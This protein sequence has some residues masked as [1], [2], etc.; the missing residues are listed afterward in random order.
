MAPEPNRAKAIFLQAVDGVPPADRAAFVDRAC[1][2]DEAL[3]RRVEALLHA[4][5]T[6]FSLFDRPAVEQ[7][8]AAAGAATATI[9]T[10]GPR[11]A[12]DAPGPDPAAAPGGGDDVLRFLGPP[13]RPGSIGR[14]GH[15]E[16]LELLGGGAFGTVFKCFDEKLHRVVAV[17]ILAPALAACGTARQRFLR[18]ARAAAAVRD[19]HVIDIHAVEEQPIPYL[20]MEY[21]AGQTLQQ[22]LDKTGPLPARETL[23]IGYQVAAGLAAAHKLGLIHR[24]VKPSNILLENGVERVKLSDFGLARAVDDASLTQSG[25]VAGTPMYMA[26]E[27]AEGDRVDHRADLFSLGSVLYALCTG[28]PPFRARTT[29][30]VLRRVCEDTPRPVREVNPD[31]PDRLEAV[32]T[33]LLAKNPDDRFPS[34]KE[35][36]DV[37]AGLLSEH[38]SNG[39]PPPATPGAG[40]RAVGK[41]N[42]GP[43]AGSR[44][45]SVI[46]LVCVLGV[47]AAGGT[48][49]TALVWP[50]GHSPAPL[51]G[52]AAGDPG[53]AGE[54][55]AP[56]TTPLGG[57]GGKDIPAP[58]LALLGGGD[59]DA[60][61]EDLVAVLA[62]DRFLLSGEPV[63]G[64][65]AVSPDGRLL[66]AGTTGG[67]VALFETGTGRQVWRVEAHTGQVNRVAFRGDG[68]RLL[69]PS[70]DGTARLWDVEAGRLLQ[71]FRGH[72]ESVLAAVFG[73]AD[74]T[75]IT[76]GADATVRVW[77][78]GSG[79]ELKRLP[80]PG[81]VHGLAL[82][83]DGKTL[84]TGCD[85]GAVRTWDA[86]SW[87][88]GR[89]LE[90]HKGAVYAAAV[91]R[92]GK[93]L[94]TGGDETVVW[95]AAT[96]KPV[97][98]LSANGTWV[99][100]GPDGG[101]V[102]A[103]RC[104]YGDG[105][106]YV[107]TRWEAATGKR[108]PDLTPKTR[109][110]W[111]TFALTPDGAT[112]F[113]A[114]Q[115]P[116]PEPAVRAFDARTGD[117]R[118]SPRGHLG[119]AWTVAFSPNATLLASGGEDG[120]VRLWDLAGWRAGEPIPPVRLLG[121]HEKW[122]W[123]VRFSPDGKLLASGSLDRTIV[124]WDAATGEKVRTLR[125]HSGTFSRVA[126]APDGRTVAGGGEDGAVR[127][128]D[129]DTGRERG[130]PEGHAAAVR[131]VAYSPDGTRLA[132]AGADR[133]VQV[134]ATDSGQLLKRI[135]MP[136]ISD[137]VTFSADGRRLL[138]TADDSSLT[139]WDAGTW[140][141]ATVVAHR[142]FV[143]GLAACP[144]APLA[145]T[146]GYDGTV[147]L[148][149][150]R[151]AVPHGPALGGGLFDG[152]AL[153]VA[154]APD[155]RYLAA[156]TRNGPVV[157]RVPPPPAAYEPGPARAVPDPQELARGPAAADALDP[158]TIPADLRARAGDGDPG[159]VPAGLVAV[160]GGPAG[161]PGPVGAVAVSPDGATLASAGDDGSVRL[162][163]LATGGL[164]RALTGHDKD[165]S[166]VAFRPD[167]QVLA[168]A[169]AD[170]VI[171]V[172][173]AATGAA[174]RT[175]TGHDDW[176]TKVAFS[177]DG[178]RIASAS[179]DGTVRLWDAA[180]GRQ[181]RLLTRG[182][183][184]TWAVAFSPDGT[185]VASGH[186]DGSVHLWDAASGWEVATLRGHPTGW[187]RAVA[188]SPDGRT[189]A[190]TSQ[191]GGD[192]VR[193]WDLASRTTRET[194]AGHTAHV[195][196]VCWDRSG[197]FLATVGATDGTARVWDTRASPARC[198][199]LPVFAPDKPW[200]HGVALTPDGRY[201]ATA[202]PDGTVY[203]L[204][205]ADRGAV[206]SFPGS[207]R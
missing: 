136:T 110:G 188:F 194:L 187:V 125:G 112:L 190:S 57:R 94:V 27:Q 59:P 133:A 152:G 72:K 176:V 33:R 197:R 74:K 79:A 181:R 82:T 177:P 103:A 14:L 29:L 47:L 26:P 140:K 60:V 195:L 200:V 87:E 144:V 149:D 113:A 170:R 206:V 109:G 62:D 18:E 191:V 56:P 64:G 76:G 73:P 126:F 63:S 13:T 38:Q 153:E 86:A 104:E 120:T 167:G 46:G 185:T 34:A 40:G 192:P 36:A 71:T 15:F 165:V 158:K 25:L 163:D 207:E 11:A 107:V 49:L 21:V 37:L 168:S 8:P 143:P 174:V 130:L 114:R 35:V 5:E 141:P 147:R 115:R 183:G 189:L 160:L 180:T 28:H 54:A 173:D 111:G 118:P 6:D 164:R 129:V 12:P 132:S 45:K 156:A 30:A 196:D 122:V 43:T 186:S 139:V 90:E 128:W 106:G 157:V 124:L 52:V 95:D 205:L 80:H 146:G 32:V 150:L 201:L 151:D 68:K 138:A 55:P 78:A 131:C 98:T 102:F 119:R 7:F 85:D 97:H 17:K 75:V 116:D 1:A 89:T 172:W 171:R 50:R 123:S 135:P 51:G 24:D 127:L 96:L 61:P 155:G 117:E 10:P 4:H 162:W 66:A 204:K 22:K 178:G 53:P 2:G 184:P 65:M 91:S 175:L 121:R 134:Y 142:G 193:L 39:H 69:T 20:V 101:T 77:D 100:V 148:W 31:V 182:V 202:N 81:N 23:R 58:L 154:F 93:W 92:D 161:H 48:G 203:V 19:E 105:E 166:T 99:G 16:V 70:A 67:H 198:R 169:G 84:V 179:K 137:A 9:S 88:P 41:A 145:A 108:L 3:R 159:K 42:R 199:V 44:K 83:P